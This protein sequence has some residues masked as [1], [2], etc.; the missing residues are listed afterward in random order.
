MEENSARN[1]K[2]CGPYARAGDALESYEFASTTLTM[3]LCND[4]TSAILRSYGVRKAHAM[5][6]PTKGFR[7][8]AHCC[9]CSAH[10][11]FWLES[12]LTVAFPEPASN[13][14]L[15]EHR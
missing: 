11:E 7:V 6:C 1:I 15:P 2:E 5:K 9:R 3:P 12:F 10:P 13:V 4:I 14:V 8:W